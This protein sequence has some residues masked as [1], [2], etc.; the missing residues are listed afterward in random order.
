MRKENRDPFVLAMAAKL[1]PMDFSSAGFE[2]A[3][4]A[5]LLGVCAKRPPAAPNTKP[6]PS[7]V[8][9]TSFCLSFGLT[10]VSDWGWLVEGAAVEGAA[11]EGAAEEGTSVEGATV[12]GAAATGSL[13]GGVS[14][15][16][17]NVKPALGDVDATTG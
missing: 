15:V 17:P 3:G 5:L 9:G 4:A 8:G 13:L 10:G 7:L 14:F 2:E 11:V 16:A 12:E 1:K 6:V